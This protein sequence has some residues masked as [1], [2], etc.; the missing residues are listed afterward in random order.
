MSKKKPSRKSK[1]K[2]IPKKLD[3]N[4]VED[5]TM[6]R[7]GRTLNSLESFLA[8]WDAAP[9]KPDNVFP[10]VVKIRNFHGA[11]ES[12]QREALRTKGKEDEKA[13]MD[14]LRDFVLICQT[15]S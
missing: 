3:V 13:R 6:K 9:K 7:V 10:Q 1:V 14:R 4:S 12:W 11:L 8:K 5:E 15:Y 2:K